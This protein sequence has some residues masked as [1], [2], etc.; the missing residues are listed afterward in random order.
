MNVPET[1]TMT[2][3]YAHHVETYA[4]ILDPTL[5][6]LAEDLVKIAGVDATRRVLDLSTGTG[7]VAEVAAGT[8]AKVIGCDFSPGILST[9]RRL[10]GDCVV[11]I[12]AD[13]AALP[14]A[15]PVFD[16]VTVGLGLSHFRNFPTIGRETRR[17]LRSGGRLV[18][19]A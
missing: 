1:A 11:F 7:V 14:F 12:A 3:I 16:C 19:S 18:G 4:S 13:A 2:N 15:G 8:G 5:R 6:P 17:V 10:R 9:A